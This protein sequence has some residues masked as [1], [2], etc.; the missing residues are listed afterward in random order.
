MSKEKIYNFESFTKA[1]HFPEDYEDCMVYAMYKVGGEYRLEKL[2]IHNI[3]FMS[4][5]LTFTGLTEQMSKEVTVIVLDTDSEPT[6]KEFAAHMSWGVKIDHERRV[7]E[8]LNLKELNE[9]YGK[10]LEIAVGING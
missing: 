1:D 6:L 3:N 2:G 4:S 5:V 8:M 7:I 9:M 10:A